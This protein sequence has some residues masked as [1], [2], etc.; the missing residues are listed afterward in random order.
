[1]RETIKN[2]AE[3]LGYAYQEDDEK[4]IT[5]IAIDSRRC[6]QEICLS[7]W[8]VKRQMDIVICAKQ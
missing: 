8:L 2:I 5:G 7:L 1:M 6:S 4:W 3:A